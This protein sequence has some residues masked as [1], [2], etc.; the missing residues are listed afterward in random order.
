MDE[1]HLITWC[2]FAL[3]NADFIVCRNTVFE[4]KVFLCKTFLKMAIDS[5]VSINSVFLN[6][7]VKTGVIRLKGQLIPSSSGIN[8]IYSN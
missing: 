2:F 6:N 8:G 5:R 1:F 7:Y 3:G 4:G